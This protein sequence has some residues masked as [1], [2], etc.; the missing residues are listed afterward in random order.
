MP[1]IFLRGNIM[2]D[3]ENLKSEWIYHCLRLAGRPSNIY[4][5][6]I[7]KIVRTQ[8][9]IFEDWDDSLNLDDLGFKNMKMSLLK[10]QYWHEESHAAALQL[11]QTRERNKKRRGRFQNVVFHCHAHN[12]KRAGRTGK[13]GPCLSSVVVTNLWRDRREVSAFWR[14]VE[15]FKKFPADLV[16]LRDVL[17]PE[18]GRINS[19]T[20]EIANATVHP[21]YFL[22]L[23]PQLD[24]P[25]GKFREIEQSDPRFHQHIVDATF[26]QVWGTSNAKLQQYQRV[27]KFALANTDPKTLKEL[28]AYLESKV[29][30][31]AKARRRWEEDEDDDEE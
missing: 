24:D 20:C 5:G 3:N 16:F 11:W 7:R 30:P 2:A 23:I 25:L 13:Q 1:A 17:L 8:R 28:K 4:S 19:V 6:S 21:M 29:S 27:K 18:F 15:I 26:D 10:N 9:I 22:N 14:T 31:R 12:S